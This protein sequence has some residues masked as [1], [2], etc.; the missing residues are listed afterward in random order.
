MRFFAEA[1]GS[2]RRR[3]GSS[4]REPP[5]A[6]PAAPLTEKCYISV[7]VYTLCIYICICIYIYIYIH[8]YIYIYTYAGQG[9]SLRDG[10]AA[11][12]VG[13]FQMGIPAL[14]LCYALLYYAILCYTMLY[15]TILY[16][17]ILYPYIYMYI[18]IYIY[19]YIFFYVCVFLEEFPPMGT[20]SSRPEPE[21]TL[22][23]HKFRNPSLES[24]AAPR[25]T[26]W[27]KGALT[28]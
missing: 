2:S 21:Q 24:P 5:A 1:T 19:I 16:C 28:D 14:V 3:T 12:L 15:Y 25:L 22:G 17:T 18:Y 4:R 11:L 8:I 26:L 9:G 27:R 23:T 10:T 20:R 7:C 6:E 13:T